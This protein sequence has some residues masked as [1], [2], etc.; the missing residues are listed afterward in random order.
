MVDGAPA[1]GVEVGGDYNRLPLKGLRYHQE[2]E[3]RSVKSSA[4]LESANRF[5]T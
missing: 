4:L 2:E 1:R 3:P 5:P